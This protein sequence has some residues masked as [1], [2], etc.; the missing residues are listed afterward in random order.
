MAQVAPFSIEVPERTID[1]IRERVACFDWAGLPDAGA[2]SAGIGLAELRRIADYWVGHYNWRAAEHELNRFPQFVADLGS[3]R[4]HFVHMRGSARRPLILTHGWPGSFFEF[5]HLVEP[6][7]HPE[8]FGGRPEDG[9]DVIVPSMPGFGFSGRPPGIIGPRATAGLFRKLMTEVLSYPRFLAQGGDW[10]ASVSAWMAHDDPQSCAGLHLNMV[11]VQARD[12]KPQTEEECAH[13]TRRQQS[14]L[15]E[16]GYASLQ[17]TRPQTLSVA[18]HDSP[19]GVAAWIIEKFAAWSDLP[20][21]DGI[22]DLRARYTYDQLLTNV[23]IY[24]VTGSFATAS[25]MYRGRILERSS[26]FGSGERVRVPTAIA[27]YP[28]PAF[29]MAPRSQVS[30][31]YDVRR[32]T[33]MPRGGHFAALETPEPFVDDLRQFATTLDFGVS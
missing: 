5:M 25:W 21:T 7:A 11:L 4:L 19:L 23:M 2:W 31:S 30:K 16:N 8:R 28:D 26:S 24:L 15:E 22:P 10:G 17:G 1:A 13:W 18:M 14:G 12:A 3:Q 27:V 29:E 32:W 6:L 9:F 20:R 33:V